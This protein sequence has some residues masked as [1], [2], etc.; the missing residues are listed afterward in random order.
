MKNKRS[1]C[2]RTAESALDTNFYPVHTLKVLGFRP[3]AL[4]STLMMN[5]FVNMTSKNLL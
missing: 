1:V 2:L 3:A 4:G 5:V